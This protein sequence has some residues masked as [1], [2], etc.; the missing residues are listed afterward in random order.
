MNSSDIQSM[1]VVID[2]IKS[3]RNARAALVRR[4][5]CFVALLLASITHCHLR[6]LTLFHIVS[7]QLCFNNALIAAHGALLI[8]L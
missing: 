3:L 8:S 7:N 1:Y 5:L 2:T 4:E 6:V